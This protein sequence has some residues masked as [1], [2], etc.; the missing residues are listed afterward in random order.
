MGVLDRIS[1][2]VGGGATAAARDATQAL[3]DCYAESVKRARQLLRHAEMAPQSYSSEALKDLATAEEQQV[4]R[5]LE[6]L[7]AAGE[8]APTIPVEP[9][10]G[11]ALN[12]W[13]RLVQDLELHRASA[14]RMRELA[15][16]FAET[17]PATA[18]LFDQLCRE[19]ITHGERLR[20]LIARADPQA[21][22]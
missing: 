21:L 22:D 11:G 19:E 3:R 2:L 10:R 1:R 16:H 14:R 8:T 17:L 12:H 5:L 4:E 13:G 20:T 18:T 7:R 6:A 9:P 15:T